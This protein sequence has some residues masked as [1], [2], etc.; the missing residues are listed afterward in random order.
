MTPP[1]P[2]SS[3]PENTCMELLNTSGHP[4]APAGGLE[5]HKRKSGAKGRKNLKELMN[6]VKQ[7]VE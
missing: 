1:A 2:V 6:S 3:A 4:E 7:Q 5:K